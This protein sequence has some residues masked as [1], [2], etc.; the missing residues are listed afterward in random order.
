MNRLRFASL[1]ICTSAIAASPPNLV[2]EDDWYTIEILIFEQPKANSNGP[3]VEEDLTSEAP[4]KIPADVLSF[5]FDESEW[6]RATKFVNELTLVSSHPWFYEDSQTPISPDWLGPFGETEV[7]AYHRAL[8][9]LPIPPS[10]RSELFFTF[11]PALRVAEAHQDDEG[12]IASTPINSPA[13]NLI[14]SN[15]VPEREA[16]VLLETVLIEASHAV[17]SYEK[18]LQRESMRWQDTDLKLSSAANQMARR[19]YQIKTHGKWIQSLTQAKEKRHFYI[20]VGDHVMN[21]FREYEAVIGFVKRQFLHVVV[22]CW[23][24]KETS[25]SQSH[26]RETTYDAYVLEESRRVVMGEILYFDHPRFGILVS[27]QK[28][29]LPPSLENLIQSLE[30]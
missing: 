29:D 28:L 25:D 10:Q 8:G 12:A 14:R 30:N 4:E 23:S 18:S 16:G 2:L 27:V 11:F 3:G 1:F 9:V 24:V 6:S 13:S 20:Q 22:Y 21:P 17:R 19:G 5:R 7:E 15:E 26:H